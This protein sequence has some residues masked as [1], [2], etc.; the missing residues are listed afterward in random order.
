MNFVNRIVE[1]RV[2]M[3]SSHVRT[4]PRRR[5]RPS[6]EVL[7]ARE[8][9]LK[10]ATDLLRQRAGA[11]LSLAE[12]AGRA[13]VNAAMVHYYFGSKAEL[14]DVVIARA[15]AEMVEKLGAPA[16]CEAS[17]TDKLSRRI[18]ITVELFRDH[19][20]L[21]R[22]LRNEVVNKSGVTRARFLQRFIPAAI[23]ATSD[24]I[25]EGVKSGEFRNVDAEFIWVAITGICEFWFV[26]TPVLLARKTRSRPDAEKMAANLTDLI[27]RG[28]GGTRRARMLHPSGEPR[29]LVARRGA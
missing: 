2:R 25:Q 6:G 20:Y 4:G 27:L 11:D 13:G 18:L 28:I 7:N 24:I 5:G 14:F 16:P 1:V 19:P 8:S 12:I 17:A 21:G 9:L 23:R 15:T 26:A 22:L 10:A 29:T 3:A